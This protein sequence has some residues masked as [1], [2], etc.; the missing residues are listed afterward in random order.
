MDET[1]S[2]RDAI[3]GLIILGVILGF[4]IFGVVGIIGMLSPPEVEQRP[5][6]NN[7]SAE[8]NVTN[9]EPIQINS[10]TKRFP[11]PHFS[12]DFPANWE[13]SNFANYGKTVEISSNDFG[14]SIIYYDNPSDFLFDRSAFTT[15]IIQVDRQI[16]NG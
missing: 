13:V 5:E 15:G 8:R 9:I 6:L 3:I 2:M 11:G 12:F 16:I 14:I 10:T 1:P 4:V 7:N